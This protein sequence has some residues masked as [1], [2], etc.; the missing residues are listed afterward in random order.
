MSP[1]AIVIIGVIVLIAVAYFVRRRFHHTRSGNDIRSPDV[2]RRRYEQPRE[3]H[4]ALEERSQ[5][6]ASANEAPQVSG[7]MMADRE[8]LDQAIKE[9][10]ESLDRKVTEDTLASSDMQ[11]EKD[12]VVMF[13]EVEKDSAPPPAPP[14]SPQ[15]PAPPPST[16]TGSV[17]PDT[18]FFL[19]AQ[20]KSIP[21]DEWHP[22]YAYVFRQSASLQVYKDA[23]EQ[24]GKQASAYSTMSQTAT[25]TIAEGAEITATP[26]MDGF[27]FK[28]VRVTVGFYE[29]WERFNFEIRAKSAPVD[30]FATGKI[31]FTVEGLIVGEIP[32]S[33]Y[34]GGDSAEWAFE[35]NTTKMYQS[36]FC[37]YSHDD[38]QIIE[39]VERAYKSLGMEYL[40]D[41][42]TLKSGTHWSDEL[43]RLIDRADVFQLFWSKTAAE[44]PY[45]KQEWEHALQYEDTRPNFIRPVWWED[46]M[47]TVPD[48]LRHIHFWHQP[49]LDDA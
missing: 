6:S 33:I 37:S 2:A 30:Q 21:L 16:S 41:I 31:V 46:P 3:A 1:I 40:R 7:A 27:Q 11:N 47:P 8:K 24:L 9:A 28:P 5:S 29:D 36:I 35:D 17:D 26:Q 14:P 13:G 48:E 44:S 12:D 18:A 19:T 42:T 49:D 10:Q 38:T 45:V 22:M 34:V 4:D 43:L 23:M 25:T 20:P 39:R 32:L 15:A